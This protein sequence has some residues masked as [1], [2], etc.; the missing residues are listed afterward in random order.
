MLPL[1][2]DQ[3]LSPILLSVQL[4][5]QR[6]FEILAAWRNC[7][8][9]LRKRLCCHKALTTAANVLAHGD[10][11]LDEISAAIL[12]SQAKIARSIL[13]LRGQYRRND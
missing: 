5:P 2:T 9:D 12:S 7:I 13:L 3:R 1:R 4:A 8:S 6:Q 10:H 11:D